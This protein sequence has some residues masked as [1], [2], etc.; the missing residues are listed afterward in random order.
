VVWLRL[1]GAVCARPEQKLLFFRGLWVETGVGFYP[2]KFFS[3]RFN[4][5]N[6]RAI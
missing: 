6:D 2:H 3:A 5:D 4:F 1:S